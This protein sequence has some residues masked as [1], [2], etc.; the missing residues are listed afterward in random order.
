[1]MT[2]TKPSDFVANVQNVNANLN[3]YYDP[4]NTVRVWELW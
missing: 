3:N 4:T 2:S 1:M